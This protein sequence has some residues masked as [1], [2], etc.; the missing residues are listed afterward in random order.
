MT[1]AGPDFS[2]Q[3]AFIAAKIAA[4][5]AAAAA[6][7]AGLA[8]AQ[9]DFS[10]AFRGYFSFEAAELR[11]QRRALT[12][13][14]MKAAARACDAWW[15]LGGEDVEVAVGFNNSL[16]A[17][18]ADFAIWRRYTP[19][20]DAPP[21]PVDRSIAAALARRFGA[22]GAVDGD[23]QMLPVLKKATA[24][25]DAAFSP[26]DASRWSVLSF[27][28]GFPGGGGFAV[29]IARADRSAT[30]SRAAEAE[31]LTAQNIAKIRH[32]AV[33]AQCLGGAFKATLGHILAL[34]PG[35]V[36]PIEWNGDGAAPLMVGGLLFAT[37]VLGERNGRRAI[38]L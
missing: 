4:A 18:A 34:K 23:A 10:D 8:I 6:E 27:A 22:I 30:A 1:P 11:V 24:S 33:D 36:V 14:Q 13:S 15:L 21:T 5:S 20:G 28:G 38:R 12:G 35:D 17:A 31:P 16:V 26:P 9:R 2:A 37:G 29:M 3:R 7:D 25:L 32:I 19:T